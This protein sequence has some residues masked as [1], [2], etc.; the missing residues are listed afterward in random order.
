MF[1]YDNIAF[2]D[3]EI[4]THARAHTHT[5]THTH[6]YNIIYIYIYIYIYCLDVGM[7][8]RKSVERVSRVRRLNDRNA[9]VT[10]GAEMTSTLVSSLNGERSRRHRARRRCIREET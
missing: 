6:T 4:H 7:T 3:K 8:L 2:D 10:A 5:H 9:H 1:D